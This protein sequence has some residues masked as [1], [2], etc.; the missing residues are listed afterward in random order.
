[1]TRPSEDGRRQRQRPKNGGLS[2]GDRQSRVE[3][4]DDGDHP[5]RWRDEEKN[6]AHDGLNEGG[7]LKSKVGFGRKRDSPSRRFFAFY[8]CVSYCHVFFIAAITL[9][10]VMVWC[11]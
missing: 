9:V 6:T 2:L 4:K 11:W 5:V 3:T 10:L 1:M 7:G 8:L